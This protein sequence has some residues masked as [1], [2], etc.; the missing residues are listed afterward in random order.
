MIDSYESDPHP[1]S[2][3]SARHSFARGYACAVLLLIPLAYLGMFFATMV[4]E[5]VGHGLIALSR[6]GDFLGFQV[7]LDGMGQAFTYLD[8]WAGEWEHVAVLSGGVVSTTVVGLVLLVVGARLRSPVAALPIL[9][10][11][12]VCLLDAGSYV[13]W[14]SLSPIGPGDIGR[15]LQ[16]VDISWLPAA[17]M[18]LG[19]IIMF[20]SIWAPT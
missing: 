11:A 7:G 20:G 12:F 2:A 3:G 18:G 6:G 1:R 19:G 5:V 15:I 4:H 10:L 8:P 9:V 14:N 13:F 16:T 17:L